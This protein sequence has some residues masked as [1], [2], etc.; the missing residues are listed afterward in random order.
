MYTLPNYLILHLARFK[1]VSQ[2]NEKIDAIVEYKD[3]LEVKAVSNKTPAK[4]K[5]IG[6]INHC[7]SMNRG[8]FYTHVRHKD[9]NWY[10][11]ND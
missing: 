1:Q 6:T 4:Y 3:I 2:N 11:M 10:E 9:G 7:G 8:H 5:L